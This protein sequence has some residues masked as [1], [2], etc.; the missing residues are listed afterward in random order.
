MASILAIRGMRVAPRS[1][2]MARRFLNTET[3]PSLYAARATVVGA[4]V[5]Y[6]SR[7][8]PTVITANIPATSTARA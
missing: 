5:G 3:A 7:S 4:R 6:F 2:T 8:P 1:V